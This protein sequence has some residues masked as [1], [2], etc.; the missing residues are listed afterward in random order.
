[1]WRR[2]SGISG[3]S[4]WCR[5]RHSEARQHTSLGRIIDCDS[6]REHDDDLITRRL[7]LRR[8]PIQRGL[9]QS[10]GGALSLHDV[11]ARARCGIRDLVW[12]GRQ[13]RADRR[14]CRFAALVSLIARRRTR[15]LHALRQFGIFSLAALARGISHHL[16]ESGRQ[17]R[18]RADG[19][20]VLGYACE[21]G[22][23][24]TERRFDSKT[25]D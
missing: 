4:A 1:M 24:R 10:V 8:C 23:A 3:A 2:L 9:A 17:G 18:P 13:P 6:K 22:D 25:S 15:L 19:A 16:G 11:S 21:L 7:P 12:D 14:H 5:R 20:C